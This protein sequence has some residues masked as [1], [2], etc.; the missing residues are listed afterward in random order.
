MKQKYMDK[1]LR[2]EGPYSY[3]HNS[4]VSI[5][6]KTRRTKQKKLI[7]EVKILSLATVLLALL[8]VFININTEDIEAQGSYQKIFILH[9]VKAGDSLWSYAQ[10]Y[11]DPNYYQSKQ[12]YIAE[13]Q[14]LNGLDGPIIYAGKSIA[15]PVIQSK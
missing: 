3:T 11:A 1:D 6:Q 10:A 13:V 9:E 15:L 5:G 14:K 12:E 2:K 8:F 7:N 4:R